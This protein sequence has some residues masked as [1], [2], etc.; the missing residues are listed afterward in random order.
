MQIDLTRVPRI[1]WDLAHGLNRNQ[2]LHTTMTVE[3]AVAKDRI[4]MVEGLGYNA[5]CFGNARYTYQDS[6]FFL[7]RDLINDHYRINVMNDAVVIAPE[8]ERYAVVVRKETNT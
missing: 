5:V 8:G 2:K 1:L 7:I 4:V 3:Q 6:W